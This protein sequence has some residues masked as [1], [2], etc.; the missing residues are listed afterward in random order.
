MHCTLLTEQ[1]AGQFTNNPR[2]SVPWQCLSQD[3]DHTYIDSNSVPDNILLVDPSKLRVIGI[4]EIWDHWA[5]RQTQKAQ[6]LVFLKAQGGD[7]RE[8]F[9]LVKKK[10]QCKAYSDVEQSPKRDKGEGGSKLADK[11]HPE[12]P[13]A[14]AT[15]LRERI[16]FLRGLSNDGVYLK[17]VEALPMKLV[18]VCISVHVLQCRLTY[19]VT[20]QEHHKN[21]RN[22][23]EWCV[24]RSSTKYLPANFHHSKSVRQLTLLAQEDWLAV[25]VDAQFIVLCMGLAL[26]DVAAVHFVEQD[27]EYAADMPEWVK[28]SPWTIKDMHDIMELWGRQLEDGNV[29]AGGKGKGKAK[30]PVVTGKGKRKAIDVPPDASEDEASL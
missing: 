5:R 25:G 10:K 8:N 9:D 3:T 23:P 13:A 26:R 11:P 19:N 6:G 7:M 14:H 28:A 27:S 12:S 29:P 21:L 17:F 18:P 4:S 24:W 20:M 15:T 1:C 16:A 30:Q 2:A 22:I